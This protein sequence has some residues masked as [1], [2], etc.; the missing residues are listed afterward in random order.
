MAQLP[1]KDRGAT[2]LF[3]SFNFFVFFYS[4][5]FPF[6]FFIKKRLYF[7]Q[8]YILILHFNS[9]GLFQ[10][11]A[12]VSSADLN[13]GSRLLF[14]SVVGTIM[15]LLGSQDQSTEHEVWT[16]RGFHFYQELSASTV[17]N[18]VFRTTRPPYEAFLKI[19]VCQV[20][21]IGSWAFQLRNAEAWAFFICYYR[22]GRFSNAVLR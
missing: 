8:Y 4:L 1:S 7:I 2:I 9:R 10:I 15:C 18:N 11:A 14:R 13:Q 17:R 22:F 5:L 20:F 16:K 3:H 6:F 12:A 19:S 21:L